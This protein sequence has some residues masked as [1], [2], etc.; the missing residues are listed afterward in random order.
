MAAS[1]APTLQQV[2]ARAT[3]AG[4]TFSSSVIVATTWP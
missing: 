2:K 3:T 4:P 1:A